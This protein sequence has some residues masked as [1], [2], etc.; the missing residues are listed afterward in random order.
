MP[1]AFPA[2][3]R[4]SRDQDTGHGISGGRPQSGGR[5]QASSPVRSRQ[6][7]IRF[8]SNR[9]SSVPSSSK[10]R[11][12]SPAGKRCKHPSSIGRRSA[13]GSFSGFVIYG[14]LWGLL[15]GLVAYC[16]PDLTACCSGPL[17]RFGFTLAL[18]VGWSV[19]MLPFLKYPANPPGVGEAAD[20]RLSARALSRIPRD[21]QE[22]ALWWP[23]G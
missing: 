7:F 5:R 12:A 20:D 8:C 13:G 18:L 6:V 17:R 19:A 11:P 1:L 16:S 22:S 14:A 2:I 9:S 4:G 21:C 10:N 23:L 15:F 3:N